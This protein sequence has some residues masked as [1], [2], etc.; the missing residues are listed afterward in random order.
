MKTITINTFS[1]NELSEKAKEKAASD[2]YNCFGSLCSDE[3]WETCKAI[4]KV[5]PIIIDELSEYSYQNR[6]NIEELDDDE[7]YKTK[8]EY[9]TSAKYKEPEYALTGTYSD[10]YFLQ[11]LPSNVPLTK[12]NFEDALYTFFKAHTIAIEKEQS[13]EYFKELSEAN[14]WYY[15]ENGELAPNGIE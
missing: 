4:E 6:Y 3:F 1:F 15:F 11:A 14:E 10:S 7:E 12:S 2:H 9:L 13:E 5:F 8:E